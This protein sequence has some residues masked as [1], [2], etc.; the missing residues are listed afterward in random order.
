MV[1]GVAAGVAAGCASAGVAAG[2]AGGMSDGFTKG[3]LLPQ[4]AS[5]TQALESAI[6]RTMFLMGGIVGNVMGEV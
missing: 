2:T 6:N 3:P 4:P 5:A 1:A